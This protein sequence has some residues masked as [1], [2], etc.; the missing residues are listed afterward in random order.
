MRRGQARGD[1]LGRFEASGYDV[2]ADPGCAMTESNTN[3]LPPRRDGISP[4]PMATR[5][6]LVIRSGV[7]VGVVLLAVWIGAYAATRSET[8]GA[9]G[10]Q[11]E[12]RAHS[13]GEM[14]YAGRGEPTNLLHEMFKHSEGADP[15][16]LNPAHHPLDHEPANLP[17]FIALGDTA[18][19]ASRNVGRYQLVDGAIVDEISYW[20]VNRGTEKAVGDHYRQGAISAGFTALVPAESDAA[21]APPTMIFIDP[22]DASRVLSI[23]VAPRPPGL[24]VTVWLRYERSPA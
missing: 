23:R 15:L 20:R 19:A 22:A 8:P 7:L 6:G 2:S 5:W 4:T 14:R 24:H 17:P 13:D 11:N 1:A 3:H 18:V 9:I 12:M 21:A 16:G 10:D